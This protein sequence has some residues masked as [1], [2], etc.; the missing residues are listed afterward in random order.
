MRG[1][2]FVRD[3]DEEL[4]WPVYQRD[5]DRVVL[6]SFRTTAFRGGKDGSFDELEY[7]ES[8]R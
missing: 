8:G 2:T 3:A 1:R 7:H 4:L 5:D 6:G